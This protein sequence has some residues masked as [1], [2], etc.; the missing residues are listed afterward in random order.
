MGYERLLIEAEK[1]SVYVHEKTLTSTIKGLY[2]DCFIWINKRQT[3]IEK[4]CVLAEELGHYHTS[5]GNILDQNK[6]VNIKQEKVA[7]N[8]AYKKLVPLPKIIQAHKAGISNKYE[9]ADY[10]NV[11]EQ[12][13]DEAIN[14][15]KEKYGVSKNIEDVTIQ[16]DPL[17]VYQFKEGY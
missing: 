10:L 3:A 12:F 14:R 11:T 13:L 17:C 9:L 7:R 16:F 4:N 15:Y 6:Y 8:W 5:S 2:C 1:N